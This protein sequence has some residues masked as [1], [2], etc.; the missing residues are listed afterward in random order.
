MSWAVDVPC[1]RCLARAGDEC[2]LP[3]G[4]L[5][6]RPHRA[7]L[8]LSVVGLRS[9]AAAATVERL[10]AQAGD[11]AAANLRGADL[12]G[13]KYDD[14]TIWPAGFTPQDPLAWLSEVYAHEDAGAIDDAIDVLFAA[15]TKTLASGQ[16]ESATAA[17]EL[18][19]IER[20]SLDSM[21]A[22]LTIS[23]PIRDN[24]ARRRLLERIESH[25][26]SVEPSR[27]EALLRGL[28]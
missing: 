11:R 17:L 15:F 16:L 13:V 12:R 27:A 8:L 3:S 7:R 18:F 19:D 14:E 23:L 25:V 21:I 6:H 1:I 26:R 2:R 24:D 4:E 5:A 28:K 20:V 22:V 10:L 9:T